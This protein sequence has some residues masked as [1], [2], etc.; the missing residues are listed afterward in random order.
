MKNMCNISKIT[1]GSFEAEERWLFESQDAYLKLEITTNDYIRKIHENK[2]PGVG[3]SVEQPEVIEV[4]KVNNENNENEVQP[5]I[6][7]PET[8]NY[9]ETME[10]E[11]QVINAI[12]VRESPDIAVCKQVLNVTG[13][14][15]CGFEVEKPKMPRFSGDVRDY[16]IFRA[17][18]RHVVDSRFSK[19]DA[20]SLLRTSL[21][22]NLWS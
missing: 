1:G 5:D 21:S 18:F 2:P 12:D 8:V 15:A 22:G 3:G 20:I 4:I 17:D 7:Q 19:K 11:Q 6:E 10:N 13:S 9:K 16:V 14:A